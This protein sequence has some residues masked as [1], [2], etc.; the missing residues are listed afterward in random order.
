MDTHPRL[1]HRDYTVGWLCAIAESELIAAKKMLDNRHKPPANPN[2]YDENVYEFGDINE[3]NVVIACMPPGQPGLVSSQRLVHPLKQSFPNLSIHLFVGIGG[4]I[5][6]T[7]SLTDPDEDI[8]LGDV[9]VGW[10]D[11]TGIPAIVQP[12]FERTLD[13]QK[14]TY[15]GLFNKPSRQLLNALNPI[16]SDRETKETRFHEHLQRLAGLDKFLHP[17]L[18]KD[19]L[20]EAEYPHAAI[21]SSERVCDG[22]DREHV[23]KRLERETT[24]PQFHQGTILSGHAIMQ[25]ARKRDELSKRYYDAVCIEMEAA[26]VIDDTHCLVIRGISDYADSHK[27]LMWRQYAAATAASFA[28]EILYIIRPAFVRN[29]KPEDHGTLFHDGSSVDTGAALSFY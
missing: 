15:L 14:S 9:I 25:S 19:V 7:P 13:D 5:P 8:H 3:H 20:F 2:Q 28:R 11:R 12:E 6:R 27:P 16:L 4:G 29:I 18:D 1:D 10:A 21:G 24:N 17:G 26:G 23:V 22:C